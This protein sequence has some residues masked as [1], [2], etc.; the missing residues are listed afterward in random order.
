MNVLK[1]RTIFT[2]S[3]NVKSGRRLPSTPSLTRNGRFSAATIAQVNGK[4]V[5]IPCDY[6][7]KD[8][9]YRLLLPG[10]QLHGYLAKE[11]GNVE[12]L[13]KTYPLV[14]VQS[15]LG[16]APSICSSC[17]I[18]GQR[19]EM[20]ARHSDKEIK[21]MLLG[22]VGEHLFVNEYLIATPVSNAELLNVKDVC[23]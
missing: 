18:I 3:S 1:P 7:A 16:V 11:A 17:Q 14:A 13:I 2:Y 21:A 23:R 5:W 8:E 20:R 12:G 19:M 22:K 9:E 6:R 4:D 15:P 10:A